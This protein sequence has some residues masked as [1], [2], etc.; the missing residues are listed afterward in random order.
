[1]LVFSR[2]RNEKIDLTTEAGEAIEV[3]VVAIRGDKVRIA[4]DA[5]ESITIHRREV[6]IAIANEAAAEET[7]AA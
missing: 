2:K 3:T 4:I 1:M 6:T 7:A 5:P